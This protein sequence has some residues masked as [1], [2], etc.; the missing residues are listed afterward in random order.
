MLKEE[1]EEEKVVFLR[2]LALFLWPEESDIK[3]RLISA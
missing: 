2:F 1:E 3:L